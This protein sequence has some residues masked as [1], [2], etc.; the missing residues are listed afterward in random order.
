MTT[1]SA[2]KYS[3]LVI[4][5]VCFLATAVQAEKPPMVFGVKPG[6][7]V[8]SSYFGL[9]YERVTPYL[10]IDWVGLS[11]NSDGADMSASLL[12]PHLGA[13]LFLKDY[14]KANTVSPYLIGDFFF[15]LPT[16]SVDNYTRAEEDYVNDLLSFWGVGIGFGAE[17]FFSEHFSVGGE[18]GLRYLYNGVKE[19][20]ETH[21][22][23]Y[24]G[25]YVHKVNDEFSLAFKLTYAA[26]SANFFF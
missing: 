19:H 10:G 14:Q 3:V 4:L 12:I 15:S 18:Y 5:A 13:K 21:D 16:I 25:P 11:V 2:R 23:Y 20:E 8:Q 26:I 17:Y 1:S 24:Y 22:D 9:G 7:I 6:L